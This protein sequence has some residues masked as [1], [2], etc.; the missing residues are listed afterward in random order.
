MRFTPSGMTRVLA[1]AAAAVLLLAFDST[2]PRRGRPASGLAH[3]PDRAVG[4]QAWG[5]V[6]PVPA[7][8][9]PPPRRVAQTS[10]VSLSGIGGQANNMSLGQAVS[11]DGHFIAFTSYASNLV[12]GDSP[13]SSDVFVRDRGSRTTSL[14]SVAGTG[15][16]PANGESFGQAISAKGRY[17]AFSSDASNLVPGDTNETRDVFVRDRRTGITQRVSVSSAAVEGNGESH[18]PTMSG[19]G[20]Y[21]AFYSYASNL[22][23]GDTNRTADAF[24]RDLR[25]GVTLRASVSSEGAEGDSVSVEPS[26][27][28]NGRYV[29][30]YSNASNLVPGDT[31]A[32]DVFVRD[33]RTQT[34][35]RESLSST[36]AEANS[37]GSFVP[38]LSANGR[39]VVFYSVGSNLV[40]GDTNA[41]GDIF[42]RDRRRGTTERINLSTSG[43]QANDTSS[44]PAISADGRYVTFSSYASN[45]VLGDTNEA[46][47][48]FL[49]DRSTG[50]TSRISVSSAAVQANGASIDPAISANGRYVAFHSDA[51]N[52]VRGD[53][54]QSVD[55]FVWESAR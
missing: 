55:V 46:P 41:T 19:D 50:R 51:S 45:L 48:V 39:Y 31:A 11:A 27:S 42:V 9:T 2:E 37:Y 38:A 8:E 49:R 6:S 33:L 43:A 1:L 28:A 30:F 17:V 40:P 10:R 29:T 14:I 36:G 12:S 52:L 26:M 21:V 15:A 25:S 23:P 20:R 47:D 16:A 5:V 32:T 13:A 35:S 4:Q 3:D 34:T 53:T 18:G 7:P 44:D 54:N 22:V 24:V